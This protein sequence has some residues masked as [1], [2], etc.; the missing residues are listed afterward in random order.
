M[1]SLVRRVSDGRMLAPVK[2]WLGM[3]AE[4]DD[5]PNLAFCRSWITLV[6]ETILRSSIRCH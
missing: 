6:V 2:S 1:K 5:V 3:P 4:E